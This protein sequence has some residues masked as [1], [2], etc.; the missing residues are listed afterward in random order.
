MQVAATCFWSRSALGILWSVCMLAE[1]SLVCCSFLGFCPPVLSLAPHCFSVSLLAQLCSWSARPVQH[2]LQEPALLWLIVWVSGMGPAALPHGLQGWLSRAS[3]PSSLLLLYSWTDRLWNVPVG[4][5]GMFPDH[6]VS[7]CLLA[8]ELKPPGAGQTSNRRGM[9]GEWL[10]HALHFLKK[11]PR[12]PCMVELDRSVCPSIHSIIYL[13]Q[14]MHTI[15]V[16][17]L[18]PAIAPVA[19]ATHIGSRSCT[20]AAAHAQSL[21]TPFSFPMRQPIIQHNMII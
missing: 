21:T 4:A 9:Q 20:V 19:R 15:R 12:I 13:A 6:M 7:K 2:L 16:F 8:Q 1:V 3:S 14:C 17:L 5:P 10:F 11:A 18:S